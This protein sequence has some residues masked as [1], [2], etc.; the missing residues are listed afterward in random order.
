MRR[1]TA[2]GWGAQG[3]TP[4]TGP[5]DQGGGKKRV[6]AGGPR[7]IGGKRGGLFSLPRPSPTAPPHPLLPLHLVL[8]DLSLVPP[9]PSSPPPPPPSAS[10]PPEPGLRASSLRAPPR[11]GAPAS[12]RGACVLGSRRRGERGRR[13]RARPP[14]AARADRAIVSPPE[15]STACLAALSEPRGPCARCMPAPGSGSWL[16]GTPWRSIVPSF[17]RSKK[18]PIDALSM[19]ELNAILDGRDD[20][21]APSQGDAEQE[22]ALAGARGRAVRRAPRPPSARTAEAV[23]ARRSPSAC[24]R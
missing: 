1:G 3:V 24:R 11:A 8:Q 4:R 12:C 7:H 5:D 14:P 20:E 21:D 13:R 18:K 22:Q 9:F 23:G 6:G 15:A 19:R 2:R 17:L 16:L 10:R